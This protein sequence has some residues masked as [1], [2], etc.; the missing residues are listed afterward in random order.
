MY[1][2]GIMEKLNFHHKSVHYTSNNLTYSKLNSLLPPLKFMMNTK[3]INL[4]FCH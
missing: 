2:F 4:I 1:L 3:R